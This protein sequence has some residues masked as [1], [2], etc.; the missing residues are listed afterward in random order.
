MLGRLLRC[1]CNRNNKLDKLGKVFIVK[2]IDSKNNKKYCNYIY[3]PAALG[4]TDNL[5]KKY[6]KIEEEELLGVIKAYYAE[7]AD[8]SSNDR[9]ESIISDIQNLNY[10]DIADEFNLIENI[11]NTLVFVEKDKT[12]SSI[13][14][15]FK[16]ILKIDDRWERKSEFLKIKKDF[17]SYV[18]SVK[19]D[20][21]NIEILNNLADFGSFK[22]A[23]KDRIDTFYD[24]DIGL[25]YKFDNFI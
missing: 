4:L 23:T 11:P 7:I 16:N 9:S 10:A 6:P 25:R 3:S 5:L 18:I 8:I 20:K 2:L 13:L 21:K 12:A 15:Q 1:H 19:I 24:N 22:A 14:E 17:Y